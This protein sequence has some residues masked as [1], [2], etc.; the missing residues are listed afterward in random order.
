MR[1][2]R[3]FLLRLAGL[4]AVFLALSVWGAVAVVRTLVGADVPAFRPAAP[5]ALLVLGLVFALTMRRVERPLG[6]VVHAAERVAAGD[7][8]VHVA[9][10]GPPWLRS[11]AVAFN[12]MTAKLAEQRRQRRDLM[13]DIA[14]ELRTPL[15]VMQGRLEGML[16]GVYPRD[17]HQVAGVLEETRPLARL[18]EDLRT[19]AHSESGTLALHKEPA[20]LGSLVQETLAAFQ[21]EA[22][23]RGVAVNARV[24]ADVPLVEADPVRIREVV[25]NLLSNA[26]THAPRGS[27]ASID[28]QARADGSHDPRARRRRRHSARGAAARVRPLLQGSGVQCIRS[29]PD[30]RAQSGDGARRHHCRHERRRCRD[31]VHPDV[32]GL[33]VLT[34]GRPAAHAVAGGDPRPTSRGSAPAGVLPEAKGGTLPD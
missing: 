34:A 21:R 8:D 1:V 32:A 11:V 7:F 22:G 18:V 16:D 27:T 10:H 31:D 28:V 12:S 9:E 25:A 29:W 24:L 23:T 3:F 30:H 19:L 13:A 26:I 20:D 17:E 33:G 14:H 2:R 6:D 15:A 4:F 5:I